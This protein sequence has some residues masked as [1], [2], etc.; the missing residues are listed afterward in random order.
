[1]WTDSTT[2]LQWLNSSEKQPIFVAN[3]VAEILDHSTVD[4]WYFVSTNDNPADIAT[5]GLSADDLL[6]SCWLKGPDF[7]HSADWP[8]QP[9]LDFKQSLKSRV[10]LESVE[11]HCSPQLTSLSAHTQSKTFVV[12]EKFSSYTKLLRVV[13]YVLRLLRSSKLLSRT[14]I[15]IVDPLELSRAEDK[16][17]FLVQHESFNEE[18]KCLAKDLP[19]P[20][21]SRIAPYSPFIAAN[22]LLRSLGRLRHLSDATY[23]MKHPV[24]LD[25]KHPF[26]RLYLSYLH[27]INFHQGVEYL[28]A[29]VN[30][31]FAVLKLRAVLRSIQLTCVTCRKR[32]AE[33]VCPPM[34]DLPAFVL[35][36]SPL[37]EYW[38]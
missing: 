16:L 13:C 22:G 15:A 17:H 38:G 7:L 36:I 1:M 5:R 37:F 3:R 34:A 27:V 18:K 32:N 20:K 10:P 11:D 2:V 6:S 9:S 14:D 28:R 26:V 23:D 33:L 30:Q 25:G 19:I 12:W 31:R 24:I 8:F 29:L 21:S 4:E 35:S